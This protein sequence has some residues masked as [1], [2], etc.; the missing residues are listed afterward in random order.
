M[1][2]LTQPLKGRVLIGIGLLWLAGLVWFLLFASGQFGGLGVEV[3]VGGFFGSLRLFLFLFT[4]LFLLLGWL[5]PI[6]VGVMRVWRGR[7][8]GRTNGA[9]G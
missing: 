7:H 5:I 3:G 4:V 1:N 9:S 8:G 6:T 2:R